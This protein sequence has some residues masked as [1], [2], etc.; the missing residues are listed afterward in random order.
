MDYEYQ[1]ALVEARQLHIAAPVIIPILDR[2]ADHAY[3][4]LLQEFRMGKTESVTLIA[5]LSVIESIK[6]QIKQKLDLLQ[7]DKK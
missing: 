4:K 1:A 7:E 2:L 5:E 6:Y 3:K